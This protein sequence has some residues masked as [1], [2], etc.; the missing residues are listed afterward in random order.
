L[1][2]RGGTL[3]ACSNELGAPNFNAVREDSG[4][5]GIKQAQLRGGSLHRMARAYPG[6]G[7]CSPTPV[8]AC[9]LSVQFVATFYQFWQSV[10]LFYNCFK[11]VFFMVRGPTGEWRGVQSSRAN[12][13][14]RPKACPVKGQTGRLIRADE[15]AW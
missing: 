7:L 9:A 5:H 11:E 13:C 2:P 4:D 3:A 14:G 6:G 10:S 15:K 12:G 8:P 1:E